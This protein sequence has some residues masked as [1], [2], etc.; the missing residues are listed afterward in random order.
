MPE[1]PQAVELAQLVELEALWENLPHACTQSTRELRAKQAAYEAYRAGRAAYNGKYRHHRPGAMV[2]TPVRLGAWLSA[3]RDLFAKAQPDARCPLPVHLLERARRGAGHLGRRLGKEP[4][5]VA[6][7]ATVRDAVEA[8]E[9][10]AR[11]CDGM[12]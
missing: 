2:H 4:P 7:P 6:E 3:M 12:A 11:W 10:L 8:L 9:A 5:V 1:M